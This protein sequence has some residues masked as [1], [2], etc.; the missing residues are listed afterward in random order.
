MKYFISFTCFLFITAI[1]EKSFPEKLSDAAI[2]LTKDKVV[3]DPGYFSISYPN[4]DVPKGKGVCTDVVIRAYR[5]LGIDLQKEVHEDMK[6][7]FSKYP[8]KWGLKKTDPNIDH[9]RVPNLQVFFTRFG[10]SLEVT[11]KASD[12]K[13]GDLVTWMINDKMPHIG[14]V[15]NRKSADGKRNL[16]VHNV[17]AGQ[18]LEDCLF[19]YKITGHYQFKK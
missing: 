4:G 17:G 10:K 11:D 7:N 12:Y 9:R 18:V 13:T 16:I 3:Y 19:Q 5:K 1:I 8:Q 14:I 6:K 2:T 15:T